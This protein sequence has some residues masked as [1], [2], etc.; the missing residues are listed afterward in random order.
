LPR[1]RVTTTPHRQQY[2]IVVDDKA[3]KTI[4]EHA[5]VWLGDDARRVAVISNATV[6]EIYGS[7]TLRSLERQHFRVTSSL[8]GDGE[9]FKSFSSVERN[10]LS[11]ARNRFERTDAVLALGGGVVGDVAGFTAAIY[12]RGIRF[13]YAPT[14]LLAQVDSSVGGK[15]GVNLQTAKNF[16]GSFHQPSG[17]LADVS[18]LRTLPQR[19]LR[20]GFYECIKQGAIGSRKL[21]DQTLKL[22]DSTSQLK[23]LSRSE[24]VE[25]VSS[26]CKFKASVVSQDVHEKIDNTNSRSRRILNFGHT[27]GHALETVTGYRRFKHGEAVAIGMLAAGEISMGVGLLQKEQLELLQEAVR[28]LG[29]LP[30]T[31]DL[32]QKA[33]VKA[34][35]LDKKVAGGV[36]KWVLLEKI[37][38]AR[39]VSSETIGKDVLKESLRKA[40]TWH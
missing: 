10:L 13:I 11:L 4:G 37:G 18:T 24:L 3:L 27:V 2:E 33:I 16:V 26:H 7:T 38:K 9:R 30:A 22:L 14:T 1:I 19:E 15:T 17:I 32:D 29:K 28:R 35:L 8:I 6:F 20:S 23:K 34:I 31:S 36:V 5:R 12:Q 25:L 39:I 40:L 21:F